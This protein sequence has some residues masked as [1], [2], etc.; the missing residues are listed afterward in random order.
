MFYLKED[1]MD[2]LLRRAAENYEVDAN[3]AADWEAVRLLC[4]ELCLR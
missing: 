1:D 2:D 4:S 3:K